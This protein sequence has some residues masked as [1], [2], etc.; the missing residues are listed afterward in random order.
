MG[1]ASPAPLARAFQER[2]ELP[3]GVW[4]GTPTAQRFPTFLAL[5]MASPDTIILLIVD[6]HAA[7]GAIGGWGG[8]TPAHPALRMPLALEQQSQPV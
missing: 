8:K 2:C 4:G 3:S 7:I 5:M 1:A 6:Y